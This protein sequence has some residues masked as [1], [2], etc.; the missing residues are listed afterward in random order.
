LERRDKLKKQFG[1]TVK[2]TKEIAEMFH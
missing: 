1:V 2:S